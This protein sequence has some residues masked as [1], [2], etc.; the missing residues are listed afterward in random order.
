MAN[1]NQT[2]LSID[3]LMNMSVDSVEAAP[4]FLTPP[5]G[6]Y[7]L[8]VKSAAVEK[9]RTKKMQDGEPDKTRIKIIYTIQEVKQL[10]DANE[11]IPPTGSM[12]SETFQGSQAGLE[13]WKKRAIE[14]LGVVAGST[15]KEINDELAAGG[16]TFVARVTLKKT[17]DKESGDTYENVNLRVLKEAQKA[18]LVV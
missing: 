13:Y 7:L 5:T 16:Y 17:T 10:A 11:L 15:V 8:G 3:D 1:D 9:Y 4:D 18:E 2:L 6:D 14:I 12:F